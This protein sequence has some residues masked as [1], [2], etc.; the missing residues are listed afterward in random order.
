MKSLEK[1][2]NKIWII[3]GPPAVGKN[4]SVLEPLEKLNIPNLIVQ[5]M[6]RLKDHYPRYITP[7]NTR[8]RAHV[9]RSA[10]R[11]DHVDAFFKQNKGK[12]VVLGG[13]GWMPREGPLKFPEESR[14]L[15]LYRNPETI[16]R[17]RY[18]R[19]LSR[20]RKGTVWVDTIETVTPEWAKD[21]AKDFALYEERG[22]TR[23]TADQVMKE[24][25]SYYQQGGV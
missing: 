24:I 10:T 19:K 6:D 21:I 2:N 12:D 13:V 1:T 14:R 18:K 15:Y 16:A 17:D 5:D 23:A 7:D 4:Y 8:W 25:V 20:S 11:Q 3:S 9:Q 22:W